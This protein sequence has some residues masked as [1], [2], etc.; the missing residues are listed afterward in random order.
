[1]YTYLFYLTVFTLSASIRDK[2]NGMNEINNYCNPY[3][4][5]EDDNLNL[6][7]QEREE[8]IKYMRAS[9]ENAEGISELI[10]G[11]DK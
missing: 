7:I 3:E 4:Y 1:M 10:S 5:D 6:S 2:E 8:I 9:R 11:W